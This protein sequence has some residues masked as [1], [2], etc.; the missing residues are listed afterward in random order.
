M[1]SVNLALYVTRSS[2]FRFLVS[3]PETI[4]LGLCHLTVDGRVAKRSPNGV[5][6]LA[7]QHERGRSRPN[8]A[9][10]ITKLRS[11]LSVLC[12]FCDVDGFGTCSLLLFVFS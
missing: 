8:S 5:E 11:R 2:S 1:I 6:D 7:L 4:L 10:Q 12:G 3:K 9:W